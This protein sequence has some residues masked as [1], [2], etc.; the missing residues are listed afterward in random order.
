M[1]A[2]TR[3]V[4]KLAF[5]LLGV[6]Q[7]PQGLAQDLDTSLNEQLVM[8]PKKGGFASVELETTVFKPEGN[9]PFPV[10][11]INHGK[12]PGDTRFQSRFRNGLVARYFLQRGY[13]VL[14]PNRQGFSKSSGS[15][16]GGG[17]NVESNGITQ[18]E[19]VKAALDWAGAQAWLPCRLADL[20]GQGTGF[21]GKRRPADC[22]NPAPVRQFTAFDASAAQFKF[23]CAGR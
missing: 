17:C 5:L 16:V 22:D 2:L 6:L 9:G 21:H 13:A 8:V 20:A 10:V 19:D 11:L 3:T 14:M 1:Q 23:C 18:A 15:C 7:V 4:L 12:A